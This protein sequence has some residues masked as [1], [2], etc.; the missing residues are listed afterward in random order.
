MKSTLINI[1]ENE[2]YELNDIKGNIKKV[3]IKGNG[4]LSNVTIRLITDCG[5]IIYETNIEN[6]TVILYPY[7]FIDVQGRGTEYYNWGNLYLEVENLQDKQIIEVFSV[8]FE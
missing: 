3:Y 4:I 1:K 6:E 2:T 7:N 5:E 8:Y